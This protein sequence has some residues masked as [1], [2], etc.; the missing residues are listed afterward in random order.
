MLRSAFGQGALTPPGAPAPTMKTLAQVEPRIPISSVVNIT[1]PG[2]YYLT[3]NI[4][5]F[6]GSFITISNS[7]VT[8]DLNGFYIFEGDSG[9]SVGPGLHNVVIRNGFFESQAAAGI[10]AFSPVV[11]EKISVFN[12]TIGAGAILSSNSVVKDCT[13]TGNAGNGL[14]IGDNATLVNVTSVSDGA[15]GIVAGNAANVRNC[16]ATGNST[17]GIT[18]SNGC[19]LSECVTRNNGNN[20]ISAVYDSV[21]SHCTANGSRA[22]SGISFYY[23]ATV[24]GCTADGNN[25]YGIDA[26]ERGNIVDCNAN[27]NSLSGI[28]VN[29]V[30]SVQNCVCDLNAF[31]G[32]IS[33]GGGYT[34]IRNNECTE[35]G[36]ASTND[37]AGI[38]VMTASAHHIE[39]NTVGLNYR[40][41]DVQSSRNII[42]HNTAV[43]NTSTNYNIVA[44]NAFGP[45]VNVAAVGDISGTV[46]ANHPAANFSY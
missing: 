28:H 27:S 8:L 38:R 11:L 13:F 7:D 25:Q 35:N 2:S 24:T 9:I 42:L 39:G 19:V 43:A 14:Q 45:I 44:G 5:E 17:Y 23:S 18:V 4:S 22:G 46:N 10:Y 20:N 31:C 12:C 32:I 16:M 6:A 36:T 26:Q 15:A 40:G 30:G 21:I 33:D 41:I 37:G 1:S 3:G 29:F 34:T